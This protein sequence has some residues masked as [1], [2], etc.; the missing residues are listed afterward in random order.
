M[1][2]PAIEVGDVGVFNMNM[3]SRISVDDLATMIMELIRKRAGFGYVSRY[4]M[5]APKEVIKWFRRKR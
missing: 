5:Q 3:G 2:L 4:G 1:N